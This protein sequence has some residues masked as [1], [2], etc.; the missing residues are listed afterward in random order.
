MRRITHA[1]VAVAAA[2][3]LAASTAAAQPVD[4][5]DRFDSPTSSLA[6]TVETQDLR[7]EHAQ[8][9][10]RQVAQAQIVRGEQTRKAFFLRRQ[11]QQDLRGEHAQDAARFN[12]Q[13]P[14]RAKPPVYWAYDYQAPKP[15]P[16]TV[17]APAPKP[18]DDTD[19]WLVLAIALGATGAAAAGAVVLGRR[20]RGRVPA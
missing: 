9:A 20:S 6:G 18:S 7:G 4:R 10:A 11:A 16:H 15:A 12:G 19:L 14:S 3:T 1:L 8:D 5:V 13:A 2:S 17:S